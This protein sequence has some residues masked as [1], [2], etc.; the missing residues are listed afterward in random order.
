MTIRVLGIACITTALA[1]CGD[2]HG[3]P[4]PDAG[5]PPDGGP[6]EQPLDRAHAGGSPNALTIAGSRAYIGVGPRLT[7]WDL[8]AS[9]PARLGETPPLRGVIEAVA[10]HAGR[11]Y[12]AERVNLDSRIHVFDVSVPQTPIEL[13]VFSVAP[14]PLAYS[15]VHA[16]ETGPDRLF[17][18][19]QEQGIVELD[20]SNP[21]APATVQTLWL[22][23]ITGLSRVGS[24]MYYTSSGFLGA[25]AGAL[26]LDDDFAD[27]G[28]GP[29]GSGRGLAFTANHLAVT[30]GPDGIRVL[31]MTDPADPV[32]RFHHG[33]DDQGPFSRAVVA[34]GTTAWV[35]AV[36]GLYTLDLGDPQA[37]VLAGP[38]SASTIGADAA[39]AGGGHLAVVTDRGQLVTSSI[40]APTQPTP[41]QTTDVTLC[42]NCVSVTAAGAELYIADIVGGLRTAALVDLTAHGRSVEPGVA[43]TPSGLAFVYEDVEVAGHHAFIADWLYGLRVYDVRSA[44]APTLVG[45]L[46]TGGAPSGLAIAGDRAYIAEGTDG[47]MLRIID[48]SN[49]SAPVQL[50]QAETSKAMAVEVRGTIAYVADESLFGPGG[51]RIFDVSDPATPVQIAL[52]NTDCLFAHD[53]VLAGDLAI[54]ACGG[55][56]FHWIDISTP[57]MPAR[58]HVTPHDGSAI[59]VATWNGHAVLGHDHGILV[60]TIGATPQ[61]RAS[62]ETAWPVRGLAVPAPGRIVAACGLAGVYQWQL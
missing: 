29:L 10:E 44:S 27:L 15:V 42:A 46:Q 62:Y 28:S 37:I 19:D 31:D 38:L 60:M 6:T 32:E 40:A 55:D 35:P 24:R 18:A 4:Q 20:I 61:Q 57:S 13:A 49:P 51:L 47:G 34:S 26:D 8:S 11:V 5:I 48:I 25:S 23:G 33:A 14:A 3:N 53:V 17:A 2:N 52:Y 21:A 16:L 41:P 50:G 9:P 45:S 12:V 59:S 54:V 36:E 56:G 1:A 22:P 43:P 30:A 58:V 39:A 7:I